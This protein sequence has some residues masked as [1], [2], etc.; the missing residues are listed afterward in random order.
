MGWVYGTI[1]L[2]VASI[3]LIYRFILWYAGA[4]YRLLVESKQR[5]IEYI[6]QSG[7]APPQWKSKLFVRLRISSWARS[8]ALRRIGRLIDFTEH[9]PLV[10]D[11]QTRRDT[12]ITLELTRDSWS[13]VGWRE[14]YPY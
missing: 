6:A 4:M 5:D 11:E 10:E 9:T 8:Y 1:V 7:L 12:L 13:E 14:I 3:V 2:I